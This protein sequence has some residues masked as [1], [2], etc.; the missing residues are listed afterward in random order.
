[1]MDKLLNLKNNSIIAENGKAKE[2]YVYSI[3]KDDIDNN[4]TKY[5]SM[6]ETNK[7]QKIARRTISLYLD[8]N[9]P[10]RGKLYYSQPIFNLVEKFNLV[11]NISSGL[12]VNSN[13][14]KT[15]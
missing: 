14:G 3:L 4:F 2:V 6:V 8:T 12:K 10:F 13:I 11:K 5:K 1:M 15:V 9:M 7:A